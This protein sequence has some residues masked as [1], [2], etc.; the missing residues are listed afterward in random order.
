MNI[1]KYE[2]LTA[3]GADKQN[4]RDNFTFLN[5][6]YC[7]KGQ[8]VLAGDSI[9]E[10]YNH[11]E[12]FAQYEKDSGLRVYNRGISGDT[13]N[14]L[15][16]RFYDNVLNIEPRNIVL[17][18]GTNDINC[19][20][21]DECI[22]A[23]IN[24]II[25]LTEKHCQSTNVVVIGVYPVNRTINNQGKR[26]NARIAE[27]NKKIELLCR[28]NSITYININNSLEDEN[29]NL[30]REFTYDGLHLNAKAFEIVTGR[31]LPL[32]K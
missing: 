3:Y 20:A 23:N 6:K 11:T 1:K 9:T 18:I 28:D 15:L 19:G 22:V 25:E 7:E 8:T 12:L 14:R 32:L 2:K 13:S 4:K 10:M 26:N 5:N 24:K 21:D 29:G 31:V 16:E 17:L 30:S 27:L